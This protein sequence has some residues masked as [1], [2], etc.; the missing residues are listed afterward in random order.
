[1]KPLKII[2]HHSLTKD[3]GT[4][5]WGAIRRYHTS[6]PPDG[7]AD[8]PWDDIGYHAGIEL[9]YTEFETF[10]GRSWDKAGAH[11]RGYNDQSLGFV[12]VGNYD[13]EPP[14]KRML[15]AG[16]QVIALWMRLFDIPKD[17]IYRHS[18]F[19]SYKSC[20]GIK[21]DLEELKKWL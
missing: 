1:M 8:G 6:P 21:F 9:V 13:F 3:S 14:P 10:M 18:D 7:P 19:A 16:A 15:E 20:P 11:C 5:S 4:V 2:I 17:K 12:F